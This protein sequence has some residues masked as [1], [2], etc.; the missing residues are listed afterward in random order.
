M[1]T[2]HRKTTRYTTIQIFFSLTYPTGFHT[3][4][5]GMRSLLM[6]QLLFLWR[7]FGVLSGVNQG[8][9]VSV[10]RWTLKLSAKA[11]V[12]NNFCLWIRFAKGVDCCVFAGRHSL[13][14]QLLPRQTHR[15]RGLSWL[16]WKWLW[17]H[18]MSVRATRERG[19]SMMRL[20]R[21][22]KSMLQDK[23]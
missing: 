21:S 2:V 15:M 22:L 7:F 10:P 8:V 12:G 20:K 17:W 16:A 5:T 6:T 1:L 18:L 9:S 3:V 11:N 14:H 4:M 13:H 19:E 23:T